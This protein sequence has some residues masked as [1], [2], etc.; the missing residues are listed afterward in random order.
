MSAM[1]RSRFGVAALATVL[2]AAATLAFA[3]A[4]LVRTSPAPDSILRAPPTQVSIWFTERLEQAFSNIEV[5][6]AAGSRVDQGNPQVDGKVM[7]VELR[8]LRPG[9][10]RVNW[11]AVS[12]D[13]HTS[14]G[15]FSFAVQP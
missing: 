15:S 10:Y 5:T 4:R 13:T 12:V 6:D 2:I 14:E 3:H 9:R 1:T 11:R 8:A 7:R